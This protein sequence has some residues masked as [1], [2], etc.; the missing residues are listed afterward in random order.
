M[1]IAPQEKLPVARPH[2]E[3]PR[4][5]QTSPPDQGQG[6]PRVRNLGSWED[7]GQFTTHRAAAGINFGS[8]KG[9]RREA[10]LRNRTVLPIGRNP[11]LRKQ[12][13]HFVNGGFEPLRIA[14]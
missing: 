7:M 13:V 1:Q 6:Y 9:Y 4:S 5:P 2:A 8:T 3:T 10:A 14:A 12:F 11:R